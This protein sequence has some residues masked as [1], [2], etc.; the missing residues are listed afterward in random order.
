ME[1]GLVV[2]PQSMADRELRRALEEKDLQIREMRH[3]T[4]NN[5]QILAGVLFARARVCRTEEA[6]SELNDAH[7]RVLSVAGIQRHLDVAASHAS[8]DARCYLHDLCGTLSQSMVNEGRAVAVTVEADD[9][10]VASRDA[11]GVGLIV[12]ELVIN[13]LKHAFRA[14][15]EGASILVSYRRAGTDWTLSVSDNGIWKGPA[16][17]SIANSGLGTHLLERLA[18]QLGAEVATVAGPSGTT[19]SVTHA[20]SLRVAVNA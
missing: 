16:K 10:T 14:E 20:R 7:R 9:C 19:V 13:A 8:V 17:H 15:N 12:S 2:I 3:R 5:L 4:A 1:S 6:R 11:V 18:K